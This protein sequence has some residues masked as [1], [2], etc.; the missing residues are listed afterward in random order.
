MHPL[1][2]APSRWLQQQQL[3]LLLLPLQL[4]ILTAAA[5]QEGDSIQKPGAPAPAPAPASGSWR[6]T[7]ADDFDTL[8]TSRWNVA[9]GGV[10]G[11][12]E[13]EL[14]TGEAVAV[15]DGVLSITTR[16]QPTD[17]VPANGSAAPGP[18]DGHGWCVGGKPA[19][20]S[21]GPGPPGTQRLNFTSGWLDTEQHFAQRFGRFS[22][23]A[24]LPDVQAAN[25]WPAHWLVPDQSTTDCKAGVSRCACCWPVGGEI[26]IME[27]CKYTRPMNA[28]PILG[29]P[30]RRSSDP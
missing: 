28:G 20:A 27:S 29:F 24:K 8:N 6:L 26:D 1:L 16:W 2:S 23:R 11:A 10:H 3:L 4:W 15:K 19:P 5:A 25:I 18:S 14:Y 7:F 22:V 30:C 9:D 13:L 21:G 17:C 12:N